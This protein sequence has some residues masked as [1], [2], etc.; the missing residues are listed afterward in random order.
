[1]Q[2]RINKLYFH[3]SI[4]CVLMVNICAQ[5]YLL[6]TIIRYQTSNFTINKIINL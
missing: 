5:F 6:L 1:M 3:T 2:L 4:N